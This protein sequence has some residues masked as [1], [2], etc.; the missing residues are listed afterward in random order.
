MIAIFAVIVRVAGGAVA[1]RCRAALGWLSKPIGESVADKIRGFRDGL[2]AI[3]SAQDFLVVTLISLAMWGM[4][5]SRYV[6]TL[7]AFVD[8]PQLATISFSRTMLLMGASLGA[9][10][11]CSSPSSAGSPR[12]PRPRPRCMSF[13]ARR[14]RPQ[15]PAARCC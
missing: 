12:S 11:C 4:I 1:E 6:Q 5:G 2:N 7:H 9:F 13:T 10:G 3:C 14:S 15:P 8:T